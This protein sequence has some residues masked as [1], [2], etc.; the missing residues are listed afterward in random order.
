[1]N[2]NVAGVR[3]EGR[4]EEVTHETV[5]MAQGSLRLR[6]NSKNTEVA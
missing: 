4:K 2:G 5:E 3:T 6:L 1:M